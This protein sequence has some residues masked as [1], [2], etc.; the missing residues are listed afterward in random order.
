M[1][2]KSHHRYPPLIP[3]V[4][5]RP[6]QPYIPESAPISA[7]LTEI[8]DSKVVFAF[9]EYNERECEIH[10]LAKTDAKQLTNRLKTISGVTLAQFKSKYIK[11]KIIKAGAYES[12]YKSLPEMTE[13]VEIEYNGP[14]RV[15]GFLEDNRFQVIAVCK[16]HR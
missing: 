10:N 1:R 5:A 3:E 8:E 13:L 6:P 16:R 11:D 9:R 14:G 15:F 12:L 4:V 2:K 7:S